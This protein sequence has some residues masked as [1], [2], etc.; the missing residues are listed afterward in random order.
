MLRNWKGE[1]GGQKEAGGAG[2][3]TVPA[4]NWGY[5]TSYPEAECFRSDRFRGTYI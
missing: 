2:G 3:R 4:E 1:D 5:V